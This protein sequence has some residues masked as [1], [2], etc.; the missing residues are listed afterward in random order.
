MQIW[1]YVKPWVHCWWLSKI[2]QTCLLSSG[3]TKSTGVKCLR[4]IPVVRVSVV[5]I[6]VQCDHCS[7]G[8]GI[9]RE[10]KV[11]IWRFSWCA[12]TRWVETQHLQKHLHKYNMANK[13][14]FILSLLNFLPSNTHTHV[15]HV[16]THTYRK[17]HTFECTHTQDAWSNAPPL[18]SCIWFVCPWPPF[19]IRLTYNHPRSSH[20]W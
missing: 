4:V 2:V 7:F 6:E 12:N 8:N 16:H 17:T 19:I 13:S 1:L 14:V 9:T 5:G 10:M 3:W 11:I 15:T 20:S 18:M